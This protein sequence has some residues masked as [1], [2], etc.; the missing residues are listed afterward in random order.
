M[1]LFGRPIWRPVKVSTVSKF[2]PNRRAWCNVASRENMPMRLAIKLGV[3]LA[4][5]TP[6]PRV[7]T[8]N[9][10]SLSSIATSVST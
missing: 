6:L 10:S 9:S 7:D 2:K 4:R 5:I 8:K 1:A 3:S